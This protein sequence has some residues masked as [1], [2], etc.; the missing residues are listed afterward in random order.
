MNDQK[1][2]LVDENGTYN[3]TNFSNEK[4]EEKEK[5]ELLTNPFE[6][7]SEFWYWIFED[8][9]EVGK[10]K[11][12]G[13]GYIFLIKGTRFGATTG[14]GKF[15]NDRNLKI[16]VVSPTNKILEEFCKN[17]LGTDENQFAHFGN[18][19]KMCPKARKNRLFGF[20]MIGRC[21]TCNMKGTVHC[22]YFKITNFPFNNFGITNYGITY[23]ML[24]IILKGSSEMG[25]C[26]E[27]I[28]KMM[29]EVDIIFFDEFPEGIAVDVPGFY[30]DKARD[31]IGKV[32]YDKITEE[33]LED[34]G[35]KKTKEESKE[36]LDSLADFI[37]NV[38]FAAKDLDPEKEKDFVTYENPYVTN[39]FVASRLGSSCLDTIY[40]ELKTSAEEWF[41]TK[42][43]KNLDDQVREIM[44][45]ML[46]K[47]VYVTLKKD[48]YGNKKLY[49]F[50]NMQHPFLETIKPWADKVV[51]KGG[52]VIATGMFLP[53]FPTLPFEEIYHPDFNEIEDQ[54]YILFDQRKGWY[55]GLFGYANWK[56]DE[57]YI[58][59]TIR[60]LQRDTGKVLVIAFNKFLYDELTNWANHLIN[61]KQIKEGDIFITYY[62][63]VYTTGVEL[64]YRTKVLISMPW[65]PGDSNIEQ[66]I[67]YGKFG[68]T[69]EKLN[70]MSIGS[71]LMNAM[72]RG[73]DALGKER[74]ISFAICGTEDQFWPYIPEN[75]IK[76]YPNVVSILPS[77]IKIPDLIDYYNF[78]LR[79]IQQDELKDLPNFISILYVVEYNA[80]NGRMVT[81][82]RDLQH[83]ILRDLSADRIREI[84][85]KYQYHFPSQIKLSN[86]FTEIWVFK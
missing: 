59:G 51:E 47:Q 83:Q 66:E 44:R 73:K 13:R 11:N 24:N 82:V 72:G 75:K 6:R 2:K 14:L 78:Y 9:L 71:Q 19:E 27:K 63:S 37:D 1:I 26:R 74:S 64:E 12:S 5:K 57:E 17:V 42:D 60:K 79:Q 35:R 4:I 41:G 31:I 36:L 8:V 21:E 65:I 23:S 69:N 85:V 25:G 81:K 7:H 16:L 48:K 52:K 10:P 22:G 3:I 40:K 15:A 50:P 86:N 70:R 28:L 20:H 56:R 29:S 61:D 30:V 18:T 49:A 53:E 43:L 38:E 45:T 80:K 34:L 55:G 84:L 32:Q 67:I 68:I 33:I 58:T 76:Y 77:K 46:Y 62:R 39:V 54:H